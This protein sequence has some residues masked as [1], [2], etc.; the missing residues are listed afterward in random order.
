[1]TPKVRAG[2]RLPR[3]PPTN[4]ALLSR[5]RL[6]ESGVNMLKLPHTLMQGA[7]CAHARRQYGPTL[8]P[9]IFCLFRYRFLARLFFTKFL[10]FADE[11]RASPV[12]DTAQRRHRRRRAAGTRSRI[13][14]RLIPCVNLFYCL[15]LITSPGFLYSRGGGWR[16]GM[17]PR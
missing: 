9:T 12:Q 17:W 5:T 7:P 4:P 14:F 13:L 16:L 3:Q 2:V 10:S 11:H 15:L 6:D 8:A 1:M